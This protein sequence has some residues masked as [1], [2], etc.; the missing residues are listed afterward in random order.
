MIASRE[1]VGLVL[2]RAEAEASR[3]IEQQFGIE[4]LPIWHDDLRHDEAKYISDVRSALAEVLPI[5]DSAHRQVIE[6]ARL[7][8]PRQQRGTTCSELAISRW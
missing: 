4:I 7:S 5:F 8:A 6:T 1:R 3:V 2:R